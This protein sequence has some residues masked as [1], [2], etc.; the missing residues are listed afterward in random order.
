[1]NRRSLFRILLAGAAAAAGLSI[2]APVPRFDQGILDLMRALEAGSYN[3]GSA[4]KIESLEG[5]MKLVRYD[6][7]ALRLRKS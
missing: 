5:T 2:P 3:R 1:M 7:T 4:L 6:N